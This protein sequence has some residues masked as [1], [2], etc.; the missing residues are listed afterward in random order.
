MHPAPETPSPLI[1]LPYLSLSTLEQITLEAAQPNQNARA[2]LAA[3]R[4]VDVRY[5]GLYDAEYP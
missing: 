4:L 3:S 5:T 2:T 1:V